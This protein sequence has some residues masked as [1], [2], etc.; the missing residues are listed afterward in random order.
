MQQQQQPDCL[1]SLSSTPRCTAATDDPLPAARTQFCGRAAG[2]YIKL[3]GLRIETGEI[4]VAMCGSPG[5]AAAAVRKVG[6][7]L[8]GYFTPVPGG[9]PV[10]MQELRRVLATRL[11]AYMVPDAFMELPEMPLG[12]TGKVRR[13]VGRGAHS[14][15][16]PAPGVCNACL[17]P[18]P[19]LDLPRCQV[20]YR[21]LP[22]PV[23][24]ASEAG[25]GG[26]E[27]AAAHEPPAT[28]LERL[29][30]AVLHRVLHPA[31]SPG[32]ARDIG[33]TDGF[34]ELGGSSLQACG[35]CRRL[36]CIPRRRT[37]SLCG[38]TGA[39]SAAPVLAPRQAP[40]PLPAVLSLPPLRRPSMPPRSCAPCWPAL[41]SPAT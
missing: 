41:P 8:V 6:E 17:P 16:Q 34:V 39:V 2:G 27:P 24:T 11:P 12:S 1:P 33:A 5:V 4:E 21:A 26:G 22:D 18:G 28:P 36:C 20:N 29:V 13:L 25:L 10:S 35:A 30:A 31:G 38:F 7:R 14:A 37:A 15:A 32:W 23:W 3:R 19:D 9:A 40:C